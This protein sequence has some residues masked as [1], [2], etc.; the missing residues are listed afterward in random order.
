MLRNARP[1]PRSRKERGK[2]TENWLKLMKFLSV[3]R[4]TEQVSDQ[5]NHR[6][7]VFIGEPVD[8]NTWGSFASRYIASINNRCDSEMRVVDDRR[9]VA[10]WRDICT[11]HTL[12]SVLH[13]P[14]D[15][16]RVLSR[17]AI[18][19][20]TERGVN[21]EFK[22][23]SR[24]MCTG[25]EIQW[26]AR[27]KCEERG[28]ERRRIAARTGDVLYYIAKITWRKKISRASLIISTVALKKYWE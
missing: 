20:A 15:K 5:L 10:I 23:L 14:A 18:V 2:K 21:I 1:S 8:G 24:E 17:R 12:E 27:V 16:T 7:S 22:G 28:G 6:A 25:V 3:G 19:S 11:R 26:N 4:D 9:S 13:G